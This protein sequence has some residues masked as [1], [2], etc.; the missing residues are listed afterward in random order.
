MKRIFGAST[1]LKGIYRYVIFF[2]LTASV[3]TC[4]LMLFATT[5]AD[6]LGIAFTSENIS[7]AAK[8]TMLNVIIISFIMTAIDTARRKLTVDRQIKRIAS[9][10][11]KIVI[12]DFD[13]RIPYASRL[14][15]DEKFNE[16]IK[17]INQMANELSGIETLRTD[18]VSSVSHE[19]KT[20]LTVIQNYGRLLQSDELTPEKRMEYANAITEAAG[21]MSAM[22][23][24]ILKLS[25]LENQQIYQK[26]E[27][28]DL[29]EQ[30]CDALLQYESIWESKN[31][32][33]DTDI[34][35]E[36]NVYADAELLS[37]VWSNLLSNAFKFTD[38]G[39]QVFVSLTADG[40]YAQV[41]IKDTGCGMSRQ[42]GEHIFE[43][44]YQGDPSRSS[45]G[46]GLGLALVKKVIDITE[47]EISVES[48]IG[49]G[50]EFT[51][52]I[53][54]SIQ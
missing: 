5:L 44:F 3:T 19:M 37:L 15:S 30:L 49:V 41:K 40:E 18:F 14:F 53:K 47:G 50:S 45:Q 52:K 11:E 2:I 21:R 20:P 36:I 42:V 28:Y 29:S 48:E 10:T 25:K 34:K 26:K 9:A 16:I 24:N 23:T 8:V 17:C 32:E 43:K 6:S 13:V 31:I 38:D 46:N 4:C 22:M 33:I 7:A 27:N 51:V 39:G 35:P 54:R 1:I 12:G